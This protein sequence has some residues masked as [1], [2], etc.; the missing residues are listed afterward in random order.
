M[1]KNLLLFGCC[2]PIS[3]FITF[4]SIK[5][6]HKTFCRKIRRDVNIQV[7]TV[8]LIFILF[9]PVDPETLNQ[10]CWPL[11]PIQ[12]FYNLFAPI[13]YLGV[14]ISLIIEDTPVT[15]RATMS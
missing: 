3:A 5:F 14:I 6:Q 7:N 4:C 8:F 13:F 12:K 1:N 9:K 15:N 2:F 11:Y 10:F